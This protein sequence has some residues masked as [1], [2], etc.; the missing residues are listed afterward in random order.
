ML[1]AEYHPSSGCWLCSGVRDGG[2]SG[3]GPGLCLW[4]CVCMCVCVCTGGVV[5]ETLR[6]LS[7]EALSQSLSKWSV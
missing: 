7:K 5:L 3:A 2:C 1:V 4:R 6:L